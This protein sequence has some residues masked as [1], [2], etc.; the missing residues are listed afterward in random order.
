M[1]RDVPPA[2]GDRGRGLPSATAGPSRR[3]VSQRSR[4]ASRLLCCS[5]VHDTPSQKPA[6]V[7]K[8]LAPAAA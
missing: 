2:Q 1:S 5:A 7:Q 8:R 6:N 3:A 4:T